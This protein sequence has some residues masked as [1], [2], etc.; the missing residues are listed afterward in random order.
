[1]PSRDPQALADRMAKLL[2]DPQ[3]R[4]EF[5][6]AGR[7]RVLRDFDLQNNTRRILGLFHETMGLS[8]VHTDSDAEPV[9]S[10]QSSL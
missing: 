6:Q 2:M 9:K 3:L 5:A 10:L 7:E 1:M 4:R 8:P